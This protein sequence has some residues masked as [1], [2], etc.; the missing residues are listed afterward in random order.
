MDHHSHDK[1]A[2]AKGEDHSFIHHFRRLRQPSQNIIPYEAKLIVIHK[3][4]SVAYQRV[5]L[6]H[7]PSRIHHRFPDALIE[8]R[9]AGFSAAEDDTVL[10]HGVSLLP[11][12]GIQIKEE[13]NTADNSHDAEAGKKH[14]PQHFTAHDESHDNK[15]HAN[16]P[17]DR[18]EN[19]KD[20][21][22][23][24]DVNGSAPA[25]GSVFLCDHSNLLLFAI[26]SAACA[27]RCVYTTRAAFTGNDP[28]H[29][30]KTPYSS[31]LS[32]FFHPYR[33]MEMIME[34]SVTTSS[35]IPAQEPTIT[36]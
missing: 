5:Q 26:R 10:R 30:E 24:A 21:V 8:E 29:T 22:L 14:D 20:L 25:V 36:S 27:G 17:Y 31:V 9:I 12:P 13:T 19:F 23:I 11:V 1:D 2:D 18:E 33:M 4:R 6:D 7:V 16:C 32:R 3:H 35:R 15:E 34:S 28:A